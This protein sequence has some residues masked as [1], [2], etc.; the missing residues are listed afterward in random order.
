M[1]RAAAS[2]DNGSVERT[3]LQQSEEEF[4][5]FPE[6]SQLA[7]EARSRRA[8][9][10]ERRLTLGRQLREGRPKRFDLRARLLSAVG[11]ALVGLGQRI[12][13]TAKTA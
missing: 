4:A 7:F 1:V 10:L 9:E 6:I 2:E 13:P 3:V 11:N 12:Q 5:M 8:F